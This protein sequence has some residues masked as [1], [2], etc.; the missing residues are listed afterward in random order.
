MYLF[1]RFGLGPLLKK[2][3]VHRGMF[4]SIPA[5]IIAAMIAFLICD[6]GMTTVR[7]FKAGGVA[8]GFFSHLLLDEIWSVNL[9]G[10]GPMV[11]KSFGTAIKFF[12]PTAAGNSACYGI[13]ILISLLVVQDTQQTAISHPAQHMAIPVDDDPPPVRHAAQ[14]HRDIIYE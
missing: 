11:K 12:G 8:L 5:L 7:F 13:L 10:N 9:R 3:T 1:L 4:H 14:P 2:F 6:T